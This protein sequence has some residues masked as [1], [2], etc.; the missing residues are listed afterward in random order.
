VGEE[1]KIF[2]WQAKGGQ[3][4]TAHFQNF[5]WLISQQPQQQI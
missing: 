5:D 2:S 1:I 3:N 4:P